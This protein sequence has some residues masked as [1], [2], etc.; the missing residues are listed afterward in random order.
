MSRPRGALLLAV[1]ATALAAA[2]SRPPADPGPWPQWRGPTASGVVTGAS[3][4]VEWGP[5][6]NV[7]WRADLPGTGNSS[8]VVTAGRVFLTAA[9]P[10]AAPER[11]ERLALAFD[12]ATGERL[13]ETTVAT[14]RQEAISP[15]NTRAAPTPATDGERLYV[16]FGGVLAA[17]DLDGE[18]LWSAEVDP[19]YADES[20][21]GVASSP[22]VVGDTVIVARDREVVQ[23][24]G[25]LAG[26]DRASGREI[27]RRTWDHTCCSYATP[28]PLQRGDGTEVLFVH[29]GAIVSYDPASGE[30]LWE[31][32]LPFNQPVTGPVA[33][34]DL[35]VVFSGADHVR[36]GA[37]LRLEGSG[38]D[39]RVEVLWETGTTIPQAAS[40]VLYEGRL[41]TVTD[42][43][44]LVCYDVATGR[45]LY[46]QRLPRGGYRSSL[47]AGDGKIYLSNSLGVTSVLASAGRFTLLAANE[48]GEPGS[49]SP[50]WADPCLLLR[51][52]SSLFCVGS[53]P[54]ARARG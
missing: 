54:P 47:L 50:A 36:H 6:K 24:L 31:H 8:P 49:A 51:T 13:W 29:A 23:G 17:L 22:I 5:E 52:E 4:P 9:R 40:P 12:L 20:H 44:A 2:C 27:W 46:R 28:F 19:T 3:L 30:T 42:V 34:G 48:L 25:W 10:T 16:Y 35:L 7:L 41:Y 1:A 39:T 15:H 14:D 26:Y 21:Y 45:V 11:V 32:P 37:V 43:G 53:E 18:V 38:A 33:E